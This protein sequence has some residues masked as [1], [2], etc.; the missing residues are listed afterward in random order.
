MDET[1][2][3]ASDISPATKRGS[4]GRSLQ[5]IGYTIAQRVKPLVSWIQPLEKTTIIFETFNGRSYAC[6]PKA[7]YECML[8]D[9]KFKK[10]T[11]VWCFRYPEQYAFLADNPRTKLV[12]YESLEYFHAYTR[13]KYWV[14][15]SMIP[16][17]IAKR[18][19]QVMLQTWHGTPLK[20]L[21][22]DIVQDTQGVL[23]T[24]DDLVKKNHLDSTR[25]DYFVVPSPRTVKNFVSAFALPVGE[26]RDLVLET[27]Y[28][29]NDFLHSY[30]QSDVETI[31]QRL[32]LPE[33][34]K[35]ILYAPTWRDDQYS[36]ELGFVYEPPIDFA[37]LRAELGD[38]YIVLFRAHYF[39]A[40]TY[41][42]SRHEGF[43]YNVSSVDD[44]NELYIVSDVLI[45]D[46][47]SVLFDFANL[48]RPMI[49]FMYDRVHYQKELRGFY[50]PPEELPGDIVST[51]AEVTS[52]LKELEV[53]HQR[54]T[55]KLSSFHKTYNPLDDGQATSRVIEALWGKK[56]R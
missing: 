53:Y 46:Y 41:D 32:K 28:P 7:L 54:T 55:S 20:R 44:I 42:F 38:E 29:R 47:S 51:Q 21:R 9:P 8:S 39:V 31:R 6:S 36:D 40:D 3:V 15:N 4:L 43:V 18:K 27:G 37:K 10:Y 22:G 11:F 30:H 23:N 17:Q 24:H 34:R 16:L 19:Q 50:F 56:R 35:V 48:Q 13:A 45:T 12:T 5:Y 49:F 26:K 14:V 33:G 52:H 2:P 1:E 25:Y